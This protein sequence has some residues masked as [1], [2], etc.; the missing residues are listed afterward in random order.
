MSDNALGDL[1][2]YIF[3][4]ECFAPGCDIQVEFDDEPCCFTHSPDA[5]SSWP[6][7]S[8]RTSVAK[9]FPEG[10]SLENIPPETSLKES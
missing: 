6:G 7:F 8:A 3:W 10:F 4:H 5:G 9:K 2:E 1:D